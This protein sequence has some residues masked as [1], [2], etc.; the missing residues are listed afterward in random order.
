MKRITIKHLRAVA[1]E[2]TDITGTEHNID[3]AY[4]GYKLVRIV[5]AD[6][7]DMDITPIRGTARQVYDQA[8]CYLSGYKL[9]QSKRKKRSESGGCNG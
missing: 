9:G 8:L 1:D 3:S 7:G 4:G 2:L 6:G 5:N